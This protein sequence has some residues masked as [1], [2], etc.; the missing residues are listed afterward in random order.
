MN[1]WQVA[2]VSQFR[3]LCLN[4]SFV[5]RTQVEGHM[6][7]PFKVNVRMLMKAAPALDV[8][9]DTS[10]TCSVHVRKLKGCL[11]T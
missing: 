1:S 2:H 3:K 10:G 11:G 7:R 5:L 8:D 4:L 6:K 9:S